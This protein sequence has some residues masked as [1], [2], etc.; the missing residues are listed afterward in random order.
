MKATAVQYHCPSSLSEALSF[1]QSLPNAK[2]IAG[3]QSLMP[4]MN[5]R[6]TMNESLIDIAAVA[7]LRE[8]SRADK[9]LFIGA[10]VTHAMIE[11]GKVED[12]A[13]GYLRKVAGGIAYRSIRN[14]GTIGGSL[15]QSD[16]AG[17]WP[18]ALLALSAVAV[19]A[20]EDARRDTP[21]QEFQVGLMET[22][23]AENELLRGV[24][25]PVLSPRARWSYMKFTRKSGE[26]AHSIAAVV[27][28]PETGIVN[29]VLGAAA[30]KPCR[31]PAVSEALQKGLVAQAVPG[32]KFQALLED[33]LGAATTHATDSYDFHLHKTMV[34]RALT[35]ALNQ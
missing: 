23:L 33:D 5:L 34:T 2:F 28:D 21:L 29:V 13:G 3:G 10:G 30:D 9:Q 17:D 14:K 16:P 32:D 1:A 19:I 6:L 15:V 24:L 22:T 12:C 25:V 11:D 26:F 7:E 31:L 8:S 4:M 27:V 20:S 18:S 35:E